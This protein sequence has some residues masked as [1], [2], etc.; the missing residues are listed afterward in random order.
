MFKTLARFKSRS[1]EQQIMINNMSSF[2]R[3]IQNAVVL[4][5]ARHGGEFHGSWF[6]VADLIQMEV[7]GV[8]DDECTHQMRRHLQAV[9]LDYIVAGS[10]VVFFKSR[11]GDLN[12]VDEGLVYYV[13]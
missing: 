11:N 7:G 3:C 12:L 5:V 13:E 4:L 10:P 6:Q 9:T 1:G 8:I 2:N